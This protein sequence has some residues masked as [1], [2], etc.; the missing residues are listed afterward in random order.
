MIVSITIIISWSYYKQNVYF[1]QGF[2]DLN[3][4]NFFLI[5][6][7]DVKIIN[8]C[9][10]RCLELSDSYDIYNWNQC[11]SLYHEFFGWCCLINKLT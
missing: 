1:N 4:S 3:Y 2:L 5:F 11:K 10:S 7:D 6:F 9:E 8:F